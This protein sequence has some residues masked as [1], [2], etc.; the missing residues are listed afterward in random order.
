MGLFGGGNKVVK[1][2]QSN[3][4]L[5]EVIRNTENSKILS[6]L[7]DEVEKRYLY[8]NVEKIDY[9]ISGGAIVK[10]KDLKVRS[11]EEVAEMRRQL[12]KEAGLE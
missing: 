7:E 9:L 12:R 5:V 1:T 10:Y 3:N 6:T 2:F 11:E 8:R 4:K